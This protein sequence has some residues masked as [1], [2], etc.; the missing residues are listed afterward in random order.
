MGQIKKIETLLKYY[1]YRSTC[2]YQYARLLF[3]SHD[4]RFHSFPKNR[5]I[6]YFDPQHDL[7][8]DEIDVDDLE[9]AGFEPGVDV[10]FHVTRSA[11][12]FLLVCLWSMWLD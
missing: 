4:L 10:V 8:L 9:D 11:V 2:I 3:V 12:C 1:I 7:R 6:D 5:S